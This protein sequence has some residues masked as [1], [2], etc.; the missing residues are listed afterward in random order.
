MNTVRMILMRGGMQVG[1]QPDRKAGR[2]E[3]MQTS[4]E[5]DGQAGK[6][7]ERTNGS[8]QIGGWADW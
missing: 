3:A 6:Q 7:T 5:V 1:R 8:K 4:K 2:Q